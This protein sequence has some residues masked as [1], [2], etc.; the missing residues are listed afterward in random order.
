MPATKLVRY[1][2]GKDAAVK[3]G[4]GDWGRI[5]GPRVCRQTWRVGGSPSSLQVE[6]VLPSTSVLKCAGCKARV[7]GIRPDW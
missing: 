3:Q 2:G 1:G 5:P 4:S 7:P 6:A